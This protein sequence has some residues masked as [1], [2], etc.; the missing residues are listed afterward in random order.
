M[1]NFPGSQ[2]AILVYKTFSFQLSKER[3]KV[4]GAESTSL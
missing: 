3:Q 2:W 1:E 4:D